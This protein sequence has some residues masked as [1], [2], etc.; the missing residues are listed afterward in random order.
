RP[1]RG[2]EVR[3]PAPAAMAK[4]AGRY[5][6]QILLECRERAPLHRTLMDL[7]PRLEALKPPRDLRWSLDIDP[8]DLF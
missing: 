8:L 5:H 2:V 7:L 3:G 4:R 1:Q 6:A